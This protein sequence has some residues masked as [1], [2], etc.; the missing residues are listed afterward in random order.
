MNLFG[1]ALNLLPVSFRFNN[2]IYLLKNVQ[3]EFMTEIFYKREKISYVELSLSPLISQ[4]PIKFHQ[5]C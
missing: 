1:H 5:K 3:N 2:D 4:C